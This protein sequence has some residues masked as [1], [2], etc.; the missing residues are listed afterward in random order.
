MQYLVT[1]AAVM[2]SPLQNA[3]HPALQAFNSSQWSEWTTS[4]THYRYRVD[5][6][7]PASYRITD[8][9]LIHLMD[10]IFTAL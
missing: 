10:N 9:A 7:T 2:A 6:F 8:T 1:S 4:L 5:S 3:A